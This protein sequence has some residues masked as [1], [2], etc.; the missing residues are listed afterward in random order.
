MLGHS[1]T[2]NVVECGCNLVLWHD[3]V[4]VYVNKSV[5]T[6]VTVVFLPLAVGIYQS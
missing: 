1:A 5:R 2:V 3:S 6:C 4:V